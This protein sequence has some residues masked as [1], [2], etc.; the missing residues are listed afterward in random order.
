[1]SEDSLVDETEPATPKMRKA[2]ES[3][4]AL[5]PIAQRAKAR[6]DAAKQAA[7]ESSKTPITPMNGGPSAPSDESAKTAMEEARAR[8]AQDHKKRAALQKAK[9]R[10]RGGCR[11]CGKRR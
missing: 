10:A 5:S 3:P 7:L 2:S 11:S 4:Y 6:I 1:M 9:R 8:L